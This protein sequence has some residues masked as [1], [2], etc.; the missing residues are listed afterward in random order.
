MARPKQQA[1]RTTP[2]GSQK[3]Q[4]PD[5]AL[6]EQEN[7]SA[8]EGLPAGALGDVHSF[9]ADSRPDK[10]VWG[11]TNWLELMPFCRSWRT[12]RRICTN[13]LEDRA[14]RR[15]DAAGFRGHSRC[16]A[17]RTLCSVHSV[18]RTW[19]KNRDNATEPGR[20]RAIP[21]QATGWTETKLR[22]T[23]FHRGDGRDSAGEQGFD[24][25]RLTWTRRSAGNDA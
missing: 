5:S 8:G 7:G 20:T 2:D 4:Q 21:E 19:D 6:A 24:M 17:E 1:D 3:R 14:G 16:A 9:I 11:D 13:A 15:F 12:A 22:G 25:R 10:Q 18:D 23:D